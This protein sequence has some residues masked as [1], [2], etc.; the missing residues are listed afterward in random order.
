MRLSS[1]LGYFIDIR[2]PESEIVDRQLKRR[3]ELL[4]EPMVTPNGPPTEKRP[5]RGEH[6][7]YLWAF[8][9]F[10]THILDDFDMIEQEGHHKWGIEQMKSFLWDKNL[11]IIMRGNEYKPVEGTWDG[12]A[13][14]SDMVNMSD[15]G[16][17]T[18][19][20]LSSGVEKDLGQ[21]A[22]WEE[23]LAQSTQ[24][25]GRGIVIRISTLMLGMYICGN[26]KLS[27]FRAQMDA[28][29]DHVQ[30]IATVGDRTMFPKEVFEDCPKE[31]LEGDVF[32]TTVVEEMPSNDESSSEDEMP[33]AKKLSS[34][35]FW[36]V[37]E[38]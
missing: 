10:K 31:F 37:T 16:G 11:H 4:A 17:F 34:V 19:V 13:R 7:A 35:Y 36:Q 20:Y 5:T 15:H 12:D 28:G 9:G 8:A 30:E 6:F 2:L 22:T 29:L 24:L 38:S 1:P 33:S 3:D 27:A 25:D 23:M 21:R 18:A 26:G 32:Q 14:T